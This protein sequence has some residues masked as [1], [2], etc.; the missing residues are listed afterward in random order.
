MADRHEEKM[1][2]VL[3]INVNRLDAGGCIR[4]IEE[5][6]DLLTTPD[7]RRVRDLAEEKRQAKVEA[8]R[9]MVLA[10]VR[11]KLHE[12]GLDLDDVKISFEQR[13]RHGNTGR[14]IPPMY[15][16][17][18]GQRWSGRGKVPKWIRDHEA[19]GGDREEFLVDDGKK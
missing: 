12:M 11:S 5:L 2:D 3:G 16:G 1:M 15:R 17:P 10:E 14:I 8:S 18:K 7:L 9:K 4:L 13:K 6:L 19:A